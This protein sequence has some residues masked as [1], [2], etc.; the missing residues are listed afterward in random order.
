MTQRK[1]RAQWKKWRECFKNYHLKK[2]NEHKNME[3]EHI[4]EPMNDN[5]S[6]IAGPSTLPA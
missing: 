2:R 6:D 1:K 3:K 4:V 5:Y